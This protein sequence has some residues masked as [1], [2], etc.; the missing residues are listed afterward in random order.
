MEKECEALCLAPIENRMA[1]TFALPNSPTR[2]ADG[3]E[4]EVSY[5]NLL[6]HKRHDAPQVSTVARLLVPPCYSAGLA[7][8]ISNFGRQLLTERMLQ[9]AC[10]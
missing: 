6:D 7:G 9:P 3:L 1:Q 5:V 2:L 10:G 4:L 8:G